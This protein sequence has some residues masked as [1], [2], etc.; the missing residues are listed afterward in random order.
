[1]N[2]FIFFYVVFATIVH[3]V[4]GHPNGSPPQWKRGDD[5]SRQKIFAYFR[6]SPQSESLYASTSQQPPQSSD[7]DIFAIG[8]KTCGKGVNYGCS[9]EASFVLSGVQYS[10]CDST[11][12]RCE[13]WDFCIDGTFAHGIDLSHV[14]SVWASTPFSPPPQRSYK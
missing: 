4:I 1:M 9:D 5:E 14:S 6:N 3:A 8:E 12:N 13:C 2:S 11:T 10:M 7:L